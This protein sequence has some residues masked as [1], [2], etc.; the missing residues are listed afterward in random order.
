MTKSI[1]MIVITMLQ[2][3]YAETPEN[4]MGIPPINT[5]RIGIKLV[6]KVIHQSASIYGKTRLPL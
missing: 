3:G 1:I 2:P 5:Q 6:K 4:T